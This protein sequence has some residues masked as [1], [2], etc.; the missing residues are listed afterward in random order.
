MMSPAGLGCCGLTLVR[1]W[2]LR[3]EVGGGGNLVQCS[4]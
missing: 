4:C 3:G 1:A 2:R